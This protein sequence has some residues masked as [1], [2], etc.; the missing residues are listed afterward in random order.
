MASPLSVALIGAGNVAWHLGRALEQAGNHVVLVY[1]RTLVKAEFLS[2]TLLHAH[3]TQN[4]D[5]SLVAADVFIIALKDDVVVEFLKKAVFPRSSLVVHTSGSLPLTIFEQHAAIRG[6]VF[7]PVQTFSRAVAMDLKQTPIGIEA[8]TP[9]DVSLLKNLAFSISEKVFDLPSDARKVIHLAA[10][11][12]CNFT[13]H[14]L[15]IS[16]DLLTQQQLNFTVLQPLVTETIQKAF[17]HAP[18]QVQTGPAVR[19]DQKIIEQHQQL[20]QDKP[21]YAEVYALLT[22][23]IQ[24]KAQE[25]AKLDQ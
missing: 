1:S 18:F 4:P 5:F 25:I 10:V 7:Y 20:L 23:H 17:A 11:F 12:A 8:S 24:K 21:D 19:F 9:D 15:G 14:L 6:G 2:E 16:H 22:E 3:P 13:N